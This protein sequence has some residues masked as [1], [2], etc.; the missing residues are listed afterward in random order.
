MG[1]V[2]DRTKKE[3]NLSSLN[4][5]LHSSLASKNNENIFQER[6]RIGRPTSIIECTYLGYSHS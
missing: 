2:N 6:E 1:G 3:R 4:F 5:L